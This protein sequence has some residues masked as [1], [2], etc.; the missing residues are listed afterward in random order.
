MDQTVP[1]TLQTLSLYNATQPALRGSH[2]Q[3]SCG[4]G[5]RAGSRCSVVLAVG[6]VEPQGRDG[7]GSPTGRGCMAELGSDSYCEFRRQRKDV[8]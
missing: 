2:L 7:S 4:S 1:T 5:A 8:S 6:A 3:V